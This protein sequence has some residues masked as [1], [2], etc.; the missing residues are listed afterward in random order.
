WT[1][2]LKGVSIAPSQSSSRSAKDWTSGATSDH[3]S[4]LPTNCRSSSREQSTKSRLNS[5]RKQS[6]RRSRDRQSMLPLSRSTTVLGQLTRSTDDNRRSQKIALFVSLAQNRTLALKF[7]STFT[8]SR[9]HY[10]LT[11]C[12]F[13]DRVN[14]HRCI[15]AH[16]CS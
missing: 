3:R 1:R 4:T 12:C 10:F 14:T 15:D 8:H 6:L 13:P 11:P 7:V 16:R 9:T 2:S 5:S